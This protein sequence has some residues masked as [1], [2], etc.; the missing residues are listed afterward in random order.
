MERHWA[1]KTISIFVKLQWMVGYPDGSLR[2]D[3]VITRAEF[4]TLLNR[5]FSIHPEDEIQAGFKFTD[6]DGSW[7]QADIETLAEADVIRGYPD[8][9]FKPD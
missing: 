6:I 3:N 2:P 9:T 7:A 4:A 1:E 5:V 8:G